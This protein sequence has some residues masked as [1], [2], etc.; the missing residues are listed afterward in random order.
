[1]S[2]PNNPRP[3]KALLVFR[4][5][6]NALAPGRSLS[7]E[8]SNALYGGMIGDE[9]HQALV[10]DHNPDD[11]GVVKATDITNDPSHGINSRKLAQAILD[12]KDERVRYVISNGEIAS[13]PGQDYPQGVWRKRN[14]GAGDHT[15]HM[16]LSLRQS[17][18]YYDNEAPWILPGFTVDIDVDAPPPI[19][20][21]ILS[22]GS[23]GED[24]RLVQQLLL[25]DGIFGSITEAAV[26]KFQRDNDLVVDGEVGTY[27]WKALLKSAT[28]TDPVP[29]E[30]GDFWFTRIKAT[31]FGGSAEVERSAYDEHAITEKEIAISLPWRFRG[32]RPL[33]QVRDSDNLSKVVEGLP[34]DIGPWYEDDDYGNRPGSR[35]LAEPAGVTI[36]RGPHKGRKSNGAGIDLS[37]GAVRA[38]GFTYS[39]NWSGFVDWRFKPTAPSTVQVSL[40]PTDQLMSEI[41]NRVKQIQET[42]K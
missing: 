11:D 3:A 19:N 38:L 6:I 41:L 12:S 42:M 23:T 32:S 2:W 13:G 18:K 15:E 28:V 31:T 7:S 39:P 8:G 26:K 21:P 9:R 30:E 40:S 25:V 4:K 27:T 22:R 16:H 14:K 24:V 33:I 5:Q 10:S 1:M 35:P 20:K 37:P 36:I 17:E 34:Q 29:G